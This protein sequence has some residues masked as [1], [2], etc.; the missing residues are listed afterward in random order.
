[1]LIFAVQYKTSVCDKCLSCDKC[2]H[3]C[4]YVYNDI[5]NVNMTSGVHKRINKDPYFSYF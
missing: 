1:M 5:M 4:M 2:T 3:V